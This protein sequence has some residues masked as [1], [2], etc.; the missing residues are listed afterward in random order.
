MPQNRGRLMT[1]KDL[2][3]A[4]YSEVRVWAYLGS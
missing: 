1:V 2:V 4:F 3:W